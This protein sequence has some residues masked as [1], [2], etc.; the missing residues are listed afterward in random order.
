MAALALPVA[1][2]AA[3]C[4]VVVES[5]DAM[6]FDTKEIVVDRSCDEV[7]VNLKHVGKLPASAM[8]HNWVLTKKDDMQAVAADG[9]AAGLDNDYV[10]PNDDRVIAYT[11]VIGG[12]EETEITFD[13]SDLDK[14]DDYGFLCSFPGHWAV[15]QGK[16]VF[17]E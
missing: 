7:T 8:G 4:S 6:Q 16:F 5:N 12:G 11:K 9:A 14:D 10:K 2:V 15:M 3:D 17:A 13:V 1:A